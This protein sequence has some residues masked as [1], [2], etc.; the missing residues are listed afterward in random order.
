MAIKQKLKILDSLEKRVEVNCDNYLNEL[1]EKSSL[2]FKR[3]GLINPLSF[4]FGFVVVFLL[5]LKSKVHINLFLFFSV[6]L[7]FLFTIYS[8]FVIFKILKNKPIKFDSFFTKLFKKISGIKDKFVSF[9][10]LLLMQIG[11]IYYV[12]GFLF[13]AFFVFLFKKVEFY[14]E[15]TFN[16]TPEIEQ[17]IINF[18]AGFYKFIYPKAPNALNLAKTGTEI[19]V[20]VIALVLIFVVIPRL[21][22]YFVYKYKLNKLLD[23]YI[24]D[25]PYYKEIEANCNSTKIKTPHTNQEYKKE[26]KQNK[27]PLKTPVANKFKNETHFI[28]YQNDKTDGFIDCVETQNK[29]YKWAFNYFGQSEED[30]ENIINSLNNDVYILINANKDIIPNEEFKEYIEKIAKN[31]NVRKIY[32]LLC[33]DKKVANRL[34]FINYEIWQEFSDTIDKVQIFEGD[35]NV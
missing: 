22:L 5:L 2:N 10:I 32:I 16:I 21:I 11:A 13:G 8:G 35:V 26:K 14:Y 31:P 7:P 30:I 24:K 17:K 3:L 18:F 12:F 33:Q 19:V 28:F 6:I 1:E 25:H 34:S 15:S 4:L 29:I 20:F 27:S 9:Y 23:M